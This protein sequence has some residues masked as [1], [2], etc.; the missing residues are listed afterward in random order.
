MGPAVWS[1]LGVW[2]VIVGVYFALFLFLGRWIRQ[3]TRSTKRSLWICLT[4]VCAMVT[5]QG[6]RPLLMRVDGSILP[7]VPDLPTEVQLSLFRPSGEPHVTEDRVEVVDEYLTAV[8]A[9]SQRVHDIVARRYALERW[10]HVVSPQ[11]LMDEVA[12]QL[13]QTE[14]ADA[15]DVFFSQDRAVPSLT[16]S[17]G[18]IWPEVAWLITLCSLCGAAGLAIRQRRGGVEE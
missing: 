1:R 14:Y 17:L 7:A 2:I 10:W 13:L 6:S 9:Y 4:L 5:I 12:G 16:T 3:G 11:L 15:V 8:D 18:A